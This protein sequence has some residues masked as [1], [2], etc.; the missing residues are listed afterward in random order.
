M[1]FEEVQK[2][3]DVSID[4][5]NKTAT[6]ISASIGSILLFCYAHGLISIVD[7]FKL[8]SMTE[9]T[10]QELEENFDLIMERVVEDGEHFLICTDDKDLVLLPY[11]EYSDYY[12]RYF[13]HNEAP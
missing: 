13:E 11:D 6:I 5:H 10:V 12:D 1:T 4:K 3:I 9:I 8:L 2:I 7:K